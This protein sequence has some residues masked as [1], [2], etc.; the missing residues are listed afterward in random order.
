VLKNIVIPAF[1]EVIGNEAFQSCCPLKS[2]AFTIPSELQEIGAE[3]FRET[4]LDSIVIPPS[5]EV[6]FRLSIAGDES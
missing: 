1:A 3:A 6:I 4:K 5:V 2:V